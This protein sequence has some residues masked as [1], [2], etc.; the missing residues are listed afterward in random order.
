MP[1]VDWIY[2]IPMIVSTVHEREAT[3]KE[4][5]KRFRNIILVGMPASGKS[6]F[7]KSYAAFSNRYFLD[8]DKYF[9]F[10]T[11][12]KISEV[13]AKEGEESFR[14]MESKVLRRLEKKH[15]HVIAM[16]GGTLL[17]EENFDFA[18]KLGLI[19]LITACDETLASRIWNEQNLKKPQR[20][21][22][23]ECHTYQETLTKVK[24][25]FEQRKDSYEKAYIHLNSDFGSIDNLKLQL[26]FYEQKSAQKEQFIKQKTGHNNKR[27]SH[28]NN[29][30]QKTKE[31][32][33]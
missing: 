2:I 1:W 17:S 29:Y 7:G 4:A 19:V 32:T 9:E 10:T 27:P 21:L 24:S 6:T 18:R 31:I 11:K 22:F 12:K 5:S 15:N 16:G 28:V 26:G 13:F 30:N 8:F 14:A 3:L 23:I 20:P 33:V 25:L